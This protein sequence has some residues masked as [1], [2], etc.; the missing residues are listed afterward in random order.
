MTVLGIETATSV[1]GAAIVDAGRVISSRSVMSQQVHSERLIGLIDDCARDTGPAGAVAVSIGPGSF[2]GLRIG[3]SVA[4]G[5][6]YAA[7]I[8]LVAVPTLGA[9][10]FRA[11]Q[12]PG[13]GSVIAAMIDARRDEVYTAVYRIVSGALQLLIPA[14]AMTVEACCS[15]LEAEQQASPVVLC[16]D[17]W[18]KFHAFVRRNRQSDAARYIVAGEEFRYC[19]PAAVATIGEEMLKKGMVADLASCEPVYVKEF[20]TTAHSAMTKG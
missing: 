6:A 8:P 14:S 5:I 11:A 9:L 13:A 18:E 7:S 12:A 4:K 20:Y 15:A 2:T 17:G 19:D 16:G 10:A 1:C 3:L